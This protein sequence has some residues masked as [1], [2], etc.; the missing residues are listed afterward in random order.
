MKP[1]RIFQVESLN[2]FYLVPSSGLDPSFAQMFPESGEF[3][4]V[5][6]L[7]NIIGLL[8]LLFFHF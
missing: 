8:E 3:T 6:P 5:L 1:G 2:H 4:E 7:I